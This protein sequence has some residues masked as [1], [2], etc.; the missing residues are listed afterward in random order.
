MFIIANQMKELSPS[1][2]PSVDIADL[3]D[4]VERGNT[5]PGVNAEILHYI[6]RRLDRS[7]PLRFLDVPCGDGAFLRSAAR[8]FP[9][10]ERFGADLCAAA[11][12]SDSIMEVISFDA[13]REHLPQNLGKFDVITSISGIMEF[14]NCLFFLEG[15]REMLS[16]NGIL[17]VS[18]DN[19]LSI[20]DRLL[21]AAF[22]RTRQYNGFA[23]SFPT[24]K[25]TSVSAL[26]RTIQEAGLV[27][28][29]LQYVRPRIQEYLWS[30]IAMPVYAV[31]RLYDRIS[32]FDAANKSG[33][34]L[35]PFNSLFSR[36]YFIAC[37]KK[38]A[39]KSR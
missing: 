31:Q 26:I 35:R 23:G 21:Y 19:L 5:C 39:G 29:E 32:G 17:I 22:G 28:F 3:L 37:R 10:S 30:P 6:A 20:R 15:L 36:H 24:W 11:E 14:G 4:E 27:P 25:P 33:L 34:N 12:T 7:L 38:I 8:I 18:N 2:L 13:A 9:A 1:A 16:E